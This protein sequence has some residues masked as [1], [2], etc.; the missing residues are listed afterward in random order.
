MIELEPYRQVEESYGSVNNAPLIETFADHC[1]GTAGIIGC[2]MDRLVEVAKQVA[3]KLAG[4]ALLHGAPPRPDIW[5]D[6]LG[7]YITGAKKW[8]NFPPKTDDAV[9]GAR[10]QSVA[11]GGGG[12]WGGSATAPRRKGPAV[13]RDLSGACTSAAADK[14]Y[15]E[16]ADV[17]A[18][19]GERLG[20]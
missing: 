8:T 11:N 3:I 2:P 5:L 12:R 17:V 7:K 1:T 4:T 10:Q 9:Q 14:H 19:V 16:N 20:Y 13:Q 15:T 18:A 6:T